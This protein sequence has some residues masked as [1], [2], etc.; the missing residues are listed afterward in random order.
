MKYTIILQ[1]SSSNFLTY[2][3]RFLYLLE[4]INSLIGMIV[5]R[6]ITVIYKNG[7]LSKSIKPIM[8]IIFLIIKYISIHDYS[9]YYLSI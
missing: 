7:F 2:K 4:L 6:E 9:L 1:H 3:V 5:D 8:N